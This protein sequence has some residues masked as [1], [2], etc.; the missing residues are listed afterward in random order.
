MIRYS[1]ACDRGHGFEGWF[2][3]SSDYDRQSVGGLVACP[4]CGS[5]TISKQLMTPSVATARKR[6][7]REDAVGTKEIA[8][9]GADPRKQEIIARM[10]ALR[11]ELLSG[12]DDVGRNFPEEARKIHYGES[13]ARGIHGQASLAEAAELVEE[14][15][16]V[17]PLPELPED[18]N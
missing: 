8:H 6:E 5:T 10:R 13:E 7:A 2:S 16:A 17:L 15:I 9:A 18:R 11:Q 12:S 3:S 14:G 4:V 1:L